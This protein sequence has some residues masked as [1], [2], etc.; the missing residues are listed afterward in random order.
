MKE[1]WKDIEGYY[2]YYQIS[3]FGKIKSL[4]RVLKN[5]IK[6]ETI[7]KQNINN[8]GYVALALTIYSKSKR[9]LVHRLIAEA[10][11]PNPEKKDQVNHINGIKTDNRIENLEWNT[12]SENNNHAFNIGLRI[13]KSGIN[14][15][16]S[17]IVLNLENGIYYDT[18]KDAAFYNDIKY[19]TLKSALFF[20][21]K[22]SKKF[23]YA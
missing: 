6:K 8:H 1:E 23:I 19:T 18:L 5:R 10:F 3:N 17:K 13:A 21:T 11:I 22:Y 4:P 20:K 16:A 15:Y 12:S 2:G 7:L 14:H 9:F